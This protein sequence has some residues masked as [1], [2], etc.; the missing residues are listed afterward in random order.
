MYKKY[1]IVHFINFF[2][3]TVYSQIVGCSRKTVISIEKVRIQLNSRAV[4]ADRSFPVSR[5]K[6]IVIELTA[7]KAFVGQRIGGAPVPHLCAFGIV[8]V[9]TERADNVGNNLVL[10]RK[11]IIHWQ[12]KLIR[13]F[14]QAVI[15]AGKLH[16]HTQTS[17]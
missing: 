2:T 13:V 8:Q 11:N 5:I 15:G 10:Y 4:I 7:Q 3:A 16:N 9:N 1:Q 12:V 14:T 17:V 6:L